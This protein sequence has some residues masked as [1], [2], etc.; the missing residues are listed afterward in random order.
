MSNKS[1]TVSFEVNQ[2]SDQVFKAI[3][4][5]TN[6]WSKDFSGN[7]SK[8]HDEFVIN[9]PGQHYSKQQV[10]EFIP[11]KKIVWLVTESKLSWLKINQQEWTNTKICFQISLAGN[12][13]KLE[14]T[15]EGLT[16]EKECYNLCEQ[17]WNIVI[18]EWLRYLIEEGKTSPAMEQAAEIRNRAL[19][20]TLKS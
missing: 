11:N 1:Y 3:C 17:G 4:N 7:S 2:S 18:R 15:H 9:H 8:L 6:W 20:D 19:K 12:K 16:P 10:V 5:I 14:F 13:T